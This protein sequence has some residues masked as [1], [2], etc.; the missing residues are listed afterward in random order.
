[1]AREPEGATMFL[2]DTDNPGWRLERVIDAMD[3]SF[4]GGHAEV[5]LEECHGD[6]DAVLGEVGE[7]VR[8]AQV[9]LAPAR[10]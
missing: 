2:V 10:R 5:V 8:Y 6:D 1:M 9:R 4:P 7:G 3:R